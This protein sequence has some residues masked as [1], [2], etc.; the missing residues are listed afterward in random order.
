MPAATPMKAS[1]IQKL[2]P[3][4]FVSNLPDTSDETI[5]LLQL[6]DGHFEIHKVLDADEQEGKDKFFYA[7]KVSV[8]LLDFLKSEDGQAMRKFLQQSKD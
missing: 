5:E 6:F 2:T 8:E 4:R 1:D 3:T 7:Y